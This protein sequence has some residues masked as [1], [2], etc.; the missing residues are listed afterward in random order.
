MKLNKTIIFYVIFIS[1]SA[2]V[3]LSTMDK[4]LDKKDEIEKIQNSFNNQ[5]K[6]ADFEQ[7]KFIQSVIK[8]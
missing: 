5:I 6:Q 4:A 8:K 7:E 3:L 1:V 2:I